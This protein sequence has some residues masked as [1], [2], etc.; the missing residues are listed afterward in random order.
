MWKRNVVSIVSALTVIATQ[1]KKKK[2][3]RCCLQF[4]ILSYWWNTF[5]LSF[6]VN[7]KRISKWCMTCRENQERSRVTWI[8][9]LYYD[10]CDE[11][12]WC[13]FLRCPIVKLMTLKTDICNHVALMVI[14]F[15]FDFSHI[16]MSTSRKLLCLG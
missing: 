11:I 14:Q 3:K 9:A 2:T 10:I 8:L 16:A 5:F 1:K 15:S 7:R 6:C 13:I 12:Y 4:F